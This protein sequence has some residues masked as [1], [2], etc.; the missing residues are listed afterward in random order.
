ME[1]TIRVYIAEDML[2]YQEFLR[3]QVERL[4][5]VKVVG[6]AQNGQ[7]AYEEIL[8]IKPDVVLLDIIMPV[9]DGLSVLEGL[10]LSCGNHFPE[11]FMCT[12]LGDEYH[13]R[14]AMNLGA[15]GVFVKPV[16]TDAIRARL[17]RIYDSRTGK[18]Q[19]MAEEFGRQRAEERLTK[20]IHNIGVPAHIKG[21]QYLRTAILMVAKDM[22]VINSVTKV[23]Y[24]E[25]ARQYKTTPSR[26]ERA[27][28]HAIES[29]WDRGEPE[30]LNDIFGYT[31]S[32]TK[33]K[34]TNSEFIALLADRMRLEN[35][36]A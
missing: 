7:V 11:V 32:N 22:E 29:A 9:R 28:R 36:G 6:T 3:D 24:P 27:I 2:E 10:R 23:L 31:V 15:K 20:L 35:Y 13:V 4:P 26:V 16:D 19:E 30:T 8:K 25:V 12:A 33:G 14:R 17:Q 5:F 1:E 34:P 21:Y 18:D